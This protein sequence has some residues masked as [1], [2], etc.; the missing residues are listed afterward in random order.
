MKNI[1]VTGAM[2]FLGQHCS[3]YFRSI[4]YNVTGIGHGEISRDEYESYGLDQWKCC[5]IT[6]E[7][8]FDLNSTFDLIIHCGGSGSVG[9]SIE[10]PKSDFDRSVNTTMAVLEF[11]RLKNQNA[12]LIYPSSPA[13]QGVHD[14]S[15]IKESDPSKPVSPYGVHKKIAEDLCFS[16]AKSFNLKIGIVRFFSIY[17][18]GI[19]KQ[20]LWDACNKISSASDFAQFWGTGDETRDWIHVSD[21]VS[22]LSKFSES[23]FD[24]LPIINGAVG[25]RYSISET[26]SLLREY[27]NPSIKI[28]FNN[29]QKE[30]DPKYYWADTTKL[31]ELEW[32]P[33]VELSTGLKKYIMWYKGIKK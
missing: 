26:L 33:N 10:N 14:D 4:G 21:A 7:A 15:P 16:Y 17:G 29:Y 27:L 25:I 6:L 5:D 20:L 8:L 11:M 19:K 18:E 28:K 1:L 32:T 23:T 30:G 2:G 13:I 22:L 31:K 3:K 24:N 12:K 9:Y